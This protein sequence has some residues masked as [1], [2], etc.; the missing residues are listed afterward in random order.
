MERLNIFIDSIHSIFSKEL[1][2]HK[3]YF[4]EY[5]K[6]ASENFCILNQKSEK[7][8]GIGGEEKLLFLELTQIENSLSAI[9]HKITA[10]TFKK[11]FSI[12]NPNESIYLLMK[13]FYDIMKTDFEKN[14]ES[15]NDFLKESTNL[16][17]LANNLVNFENKIYNSKINLT[18][19][20]IRKSLNYNDFKAYF[21]SLQKAID[22]D[23][24]S[25]ISQEIVD[26]SY[27]F[28]VNYENMMTSLNKVNSELPKILEFIKLTNNLMVKKIWIKNT[29]EKL[30]KKEQK[31][32]EIQN[33][34]MRIQAFYNNTELCIREMEED[35]QTINKQIIKTRNRASYE[36]QVK[37][38]K[39]LNILN[40][41]QK[42]GINERYI[43]YAEIENSH[44]MKHKIML[45]NEF[46]VK[47]QFST[48]VFN[49]L[50]N[51]ENGTTTGF[52]REII[53]QILDTKPKSRNLMETE[54][55][56]LEEIASPISKK[57]L[58]FK[59]IIY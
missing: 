52:D 25:F 55:K 27:P 42:Y 6:E 34:L 21:S 16:G 10:N 24:L 29:E 7:Y 17:N 4:E 37:Q 47:N 23:D 11:I 18:W 33:N 50:A 43:V 36:E 30:H 54:N 1:G 32:K 14:Q 44:T 49:S 45:K 5:K 59:F 48:H 46:K 31:I 15:E 57:I 20:Q 39:K 3:S 26:S 53:E 40:L 2:K 22:N 8:S 51:Y 12:K 35:I 38:S 41:I 28:A 13:T 56:E 19:E 9:F 58:L